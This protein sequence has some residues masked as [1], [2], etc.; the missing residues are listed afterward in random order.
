MRIAGLQ[1][2]GLKSFPEV[3]GLF[4]L[5]S[6]N[7]PRQRLHVLP[8]LFLDRIFYWDVTLTKLIR[9]IA[10]EKYDL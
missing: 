4:K 2:A 9:V 3:S 7:P 1:K 8:R 6:V 10:K 5:R